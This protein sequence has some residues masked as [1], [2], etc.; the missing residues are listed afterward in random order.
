[1]QDRNPNTDEKRL[2]RIQVSHAAAVERPRTRTSAR[3]LALPNT[4]KAQIPT[5]V[6][7]VRRHVPADVTK[8]KS[9]P[10]QAL[11][12]PKAMVLGGALQTEPLR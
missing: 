10:T 1:M 11:L 12:V 4:S 5:L 7:A 8:K 9:C 3:A 2:Q 6:W